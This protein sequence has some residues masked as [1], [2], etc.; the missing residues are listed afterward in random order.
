MAIPGAS[1]VTR[2]VGSEIMERLG[3]FAP[4][5]LS[6]KQTIDYMGQGLQR[7]IDSGKVTIPA[8][9]TAAKNKQFSVIQDQVNFGQEALVKE[10]RNGEISKV[11]T[12]TVQSG[13]AKSYNVTGKEGREFVHGKLSEWIKEQQGL[14]EAGEISKIDRSQFAP[15][16]LMID[17]E[18]RGISGIS[19]HIRSS[20]KSRIKMDALGP[21]QARARQA[22]PA[23]VQGLK[24][25]FESGHQTWKETGGA[26]G[27]HPDLNFDEFRSST[28][29]GAAKADKVTSEL[30]KDLGIKLDKEHMASLGGR[31]SNDARSQIPGSASYNRSM[32]KIDSFNREVMEILGLPGSGSMKATPL[33][34][35]A[36]VAAKDAQRAQKGWWQSATDWVATDGGTMDDMSKWNP[37]DILTDSDKL[38]IQQNPGAGQANLAMEILAERQIVEAYVRAGLGKKANEKALLGRILKHIDA[39]TALRKALREA[40]EGMPENQLKELAKKYPNETQEQLFERTNKSVAYRTSQ[41]KQSRVAREGIKNVIKLDRAGNVIPPKELTEISPGV[42][43]NKN[44]KPGND[45]ALDAVLKKLAQDP[46]SLD[47]SG[48]GTS[49]NVNQMK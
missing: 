13:Y 45:P 24:E 19:E 20:Y 6:N 1:T 40:K 25:W 44:Y 5:L 38:I 32:G 30:A 8:L 42:M 23:N 26:E 47:S 3:K 34:K 10:A 12:P 21:A 29:R 43:V 27:I 16:G 41:A 49:F 7:Q 35:S 48:M 39:K 28:L 22:D 37:G 11:V 31:G 33:R 36:E 9:E 46:S 15:E 2:K 17:G 4:D 14:V 18:E